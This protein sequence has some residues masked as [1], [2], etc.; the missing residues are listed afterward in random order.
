[1]LIH[2]TLVPTKSANHSQMPMLDSSVLM[3]GS[4]QQQTEA[5][6]ATQT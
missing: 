3:L 2:A 5:G 1:M 6:A 4:P